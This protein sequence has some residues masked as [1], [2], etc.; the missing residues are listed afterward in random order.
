MVSPFIFMYDLSA[1][2]RPGGRFA[3]AAFSRGGHSH[4]VA[5]FDSGHGESATGRPGGRPL[6]DYYIFSIISLAT[7]TPLAEAWDRECVMP[8]PSPMIYSPL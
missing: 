3:L 1:T 2:G 7:C 8:L 6:R 5:V 4:T